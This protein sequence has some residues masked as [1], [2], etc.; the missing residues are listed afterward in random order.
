MRISDWSSDVCSSDLENCCGGVL[1]NPVRSL[2]RGPDGFPVAS[3][4]TLLPLLQFLGANHQ[5]APAGASFIRRQST[6]PGVDYRSDTKDWGVSGELGWD[7]AGATL[8]SID[9]KST[10]LNSSH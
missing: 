9:R 3:P 4:N 2:T 6:T 5:V 10:R 7:F 1:L 8:T